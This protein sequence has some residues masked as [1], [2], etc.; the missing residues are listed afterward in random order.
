M[1]VVLNNFFYVVLNNIFSIMHVVLNYFFDGDV[2][3]EYFQSR[4][5]GAVR[6]E[7]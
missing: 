3:S 6:D 7:S 2:M 1:H 4:I 5:G